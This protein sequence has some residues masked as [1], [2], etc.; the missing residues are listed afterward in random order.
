MGKT[1]KWLF[2][3]SVI[4]NFILAFLVWSIYTEHSDKLGILN[5]DIKIGLFNDQ[6]KSVFFNLPKG[7]T[8]Q[9]VSERGIGAIYLFENNRFE[10][11]ITS[12]Q[13]DLVNYN[14]PANK[15]S[16]FGNLY[17]ADATNK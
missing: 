6:G 8:V 13:Q 11:V 15:L 5:K 9:D 3:I 2:R 14:I 7:I 16:Q 4:A 1:K 12:N 17:S 10:I